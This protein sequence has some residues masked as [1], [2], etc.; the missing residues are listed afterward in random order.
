[1][2]EPLGSASTP[3]S[4][5]ERA[6]A[7]ELAPDLFARAERAESRARAANGDAA[8]EHAERARWLFEAALAEADRIELERRVI[9]LALS[10][11]T[12]ARARAAEV[13]LTL[14]LADE[15][16]RER[17]RRQAEREPQPLAADAALRRA[18]SLIAAARALGAEPGGL[19][20]VE[21][22]LASAKN[23]QAARVAL[24]HAEQLLAR[25]RGQHAPAG[26]AD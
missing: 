8:R 19:E 17:A 6:R 1:V 16:R 3:A 10:Q 4:A 25:A 14:V 24:E 7:A 11:D 5:A 9:A 15:L 12:L 22:R 20:R 2:S 21:A 13:R 26:P 18:R 23:A